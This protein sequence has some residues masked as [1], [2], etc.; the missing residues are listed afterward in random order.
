MLLM[1]EWRK[2]RTEVRQR[3]CGDGKRESCSHDERHDGRFDG[4]LTQGS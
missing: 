1:R 4:L 2:A 3:T